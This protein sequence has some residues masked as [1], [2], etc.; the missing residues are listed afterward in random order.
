M[1]PDMAWGILIGAMG[2]VGL[3]AIAFIWLLVAAVRREARKRT[4]TAEPTTLRV[5]DADLPK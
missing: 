5:V 1:S 2:M 3:E 4:A